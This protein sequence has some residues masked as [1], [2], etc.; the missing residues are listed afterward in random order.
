[1]RAIT[2]H[3]YGT[4]DVLAL[5]DVP[6]PDIGATDVRIRVH[7]AGVDRGVWHLMTGL[8]YPARLAFGLRRPRNPILGMDVAGIVEAVG[9]D[10]TRFTEGDAVFGVGQGTWAD[11]VAIDQD[12][13]AAVPRGVDM[14]A[15]GALAVSGSTAMQAVEDHGCVQP[16]DRV[17]VLGASGGV[18]S[19]AVQVA[20]AHDAHVTGTASTDKLD[21]VRDLGAHQVI[22]HRKDDPLA[23]HD[24][25]DV[26][27]D[28][29]G[30]RRLRDLR[31]ALR[32]AGTLVI[33]GGEGGGRLIGGLDRQLRAVLTSAFTRQRLVTFVATEDAD[34]LER[35]AD[36][37]EAGHV[38]PRVGQSFPLEEAASAMRLLEAGRGKL[39]LAVAGAQPETSTP[40]K[41]NTAERP[42]QESNVRR[43]V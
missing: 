32:P 42:R 22:D 41:H 17:L 19:Y 37:V 12:R 18:G 4:T 11:L 15:A 43:T 25:F 40:A 28:T 31:H 5:E 24:R 29:G 27:I 34:H 3:T 8:P 9:H 7:A 26:I 13:L 33:V 36:L 39:V 38:T 21:L 30:N 35:L 20:R 14:L 1:M 2:Q 16:G 23:Q 10:V 6:I